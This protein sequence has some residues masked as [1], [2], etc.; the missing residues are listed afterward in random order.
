MVNLRRVYTTDSK[1]TKHVLSH[2]F[3]NDQVDYKLY[4]DL[5]NVY[6]KVEEFDLYIVNPTALCFNDEQ[7]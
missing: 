5:Y 3:E 2:C 7:S 4:I 6:F 1:W